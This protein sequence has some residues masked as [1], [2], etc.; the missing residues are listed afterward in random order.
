MSLLF[1]NAFNSLKTN[2][3]SLQTISDDIAKSI[4]T[5]PGNNGNSQKP[6]SILTIDE[7]AV[8][9]SETNSYPSQQITPIEQSSIDLVTAMVDLVVA[10][11]DIAATVFTIKVISDTEGSLFKIR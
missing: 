3:Q 8:A 6:P 5:T 11:R 7:V 1:D 4:L 9:P 10:Q 2:M